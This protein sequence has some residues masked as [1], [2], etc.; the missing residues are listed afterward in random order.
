MWHF[1]TGLTVLLASINWGNINLTVKTNEPFNFVFAK[2][3]N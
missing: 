1:N 3:K 2:K